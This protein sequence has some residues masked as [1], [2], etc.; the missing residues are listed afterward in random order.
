MNA[1]R[2][3]APGDRNRRIGVVHLALVLLMLGILG[4]AAHVQLVQGRAW[5]DLAR[6]QHFTAREIPAPRGRILDATGRT[7]AT[8]RE[9]VSLAVAPRELRDRDRLRRA[10]VAARVTPAAAAAATDPARQWVTVPGRFVAEDVAPITAMRGVYTTP[11]SERA[12]SMTPSLGPLVGRVSNGE[13]LDGLELMLDSLL[14]GVPGASQMVRAIGSGGRNFVSP[15]APGIAPTQGHSVTLTI[16]HELQE[17]AERALADAVRRLDADGGDIVIMD[18]RNGELLAMAGERG[19]RVA[20]SVTALSE[21]FEPGSTV[22]PIVAAG[23]LARGRARPGDMV[24]SM[25]GRYTLHGRTIHDEPH[26]GPTP[27]R[28]TLAEV[29]RYSSNVGIVQFAERLTEREEYE[30]L[31]DFGLGSPTGLPYAAEAAGTLRP[32]LVWSRQSQASLA[33]GYELAVTPVQL[34]AAYAAIANGGEL[35][36]PALIREIRDPGGDVVYRH[37]RRIVR[38]VI[39]EQVARTVRSLLT[40]VVERGTAVDAELATYTLGGKTGT[41][42]RTVNG[43]YAPRQYNPN[44]VGLFPA[45]S[46]Q[47]V[48]V[49]KLTNPKGNFYSSKTAAPTTKTILQAALAAR[50]AALDRSRL[51]TR[52]A[53]AEQAGRSVAPALSVAPIEAS[54]IT[55]DDATTRVVVALPPPPSSKPAQPPPRAVPNVRGLSLRDAVRSLH[56]AGFR[57]QLARGAPGPRV[58]DPAPGALAAAGSL[59]RLRHDP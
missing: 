29:I 1:E 34:A 19:G 40:A 2:R 5:G 8:T 21:P 6:R 9:V 48:I 35:L 16:N 20:G 49:V 54:W 13:G 52:H 27:P 50:D 42:R 47:L 39:P 26:D 22:K 53:G 32:P 37:E 38:R 31:R 59:V 41:P 3:Q 7:L 46:P 28:L 43:R 25:G 36:E 17:I 30:T 45:E 11:V 33:M 12:Y 57:V 56:T 4:K 44:F 23:L 10:L 58:T 14:R 15:T 24:P 51:A 55:S 18:P